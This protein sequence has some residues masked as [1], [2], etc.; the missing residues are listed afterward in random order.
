MDEE[1]GVVGRCGG[2]CGGQRGEQ[3]G[4]EG[5]AEGRAEAERDGGGAGHVHRGTGQRPH[6]A[7]PGPQQFGGCVRGL[8]AL[9]L[10]LFL[11]RLHY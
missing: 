9:H 11:L 1:E 7:G 10:A 4:G 3:D 2:G 5:T 8:A 6:P